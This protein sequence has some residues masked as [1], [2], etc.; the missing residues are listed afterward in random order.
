MDIDDLTDDELITLLRSRKTPKLARDINRFIGK[1]IADHMEA[2][3]IVLVCPECGCAEKFNNGTTK[4]GTPRYKCKNEKCGKGYSATTNTIFEGTDYSW[5]DMVN[6][7]KNTINETTLSNLQSSIKTDHSKTA[8]ASAWFI[9][10]KIIRILANIPQEVKLKGNIQID[11]KYFRE[12]QKGSHKLIDLTG[13][14]PTRKKRRNG[15]ASKAGI[16]GPE[17]VNVL[18]ATDENDY[19]WAKPVCLGPMGLEELKEIE[20]SLG[21]VSY[22]CSDAYEAYSLWCAEHNWQHY[23]EPST[24]RKERKARG[25][26]D[27][28][29]AY[30]VLTDEDY[31]NNKKINEKL[32]KDGIYPH[33]EGAGRKLSYDELVALKYKFHLTINGVN[34]MHSLLTDKWQGKKTG[35]TDYIADFIGKEVFLHNYRKINLIQDSSFTYFEAEKILIKM[36]QYTIKEKHSPTE[37]EI[38]EATF[39]NLTKPSKKEINK[40]IRDI[41]KLRGYVEI[42]KKAKY[43]DK[44]AY[45]GDDENT[46]FIFNKYKFFDKAISTE[47]RN[48]LIYSNGLYRKG[49]RKSEKVQLLAQLPNAQDIIFYEIWLSNYG[50]MDEWKKTITNLGNQTK[51]KKRQRN[52]SSSS[53]LSTYRKMKRICFDV[54]ITGLNENKDD[55]ILSLAIIDGSGNILFNKVFKPVNHTTWPEAEKVNNLTYDMLKDKKTFSDYKEEIQKIINDNNIMIG[56]NLDFDMTLLRQQGIEFI[57]KTEFDVQKEFDLLKKRKRSSLRF[58]AD[59]YEYNW[60]KGS[61]HTSIGDIYA[62]MFCF[63]KI[64]KEKDES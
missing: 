23:V 56:F 36:L 10:R 9:R 22:I 4:S 59:F 30:R 34:T 6:A 25:Y 20:S 8:K 3:G 62:T 40:A 31:E 57:N 24:Y 51:G 16:F 12:S 19:W 29:D 61:A 39:F 38:M 27:T 41:A 15:Q 21:E 44:R 64:L 46:Q 17:F 63:E 11:E 48:D 5:E 47:R 28:D 32:Y 42:P 13:E 53:L 18:C 1:N 55:E 49:M 7:V 37:K 52:S 43:P 2:N 35:S 50:T 45:E 58:V 33:I 54:E 60:K 14:K 26:I